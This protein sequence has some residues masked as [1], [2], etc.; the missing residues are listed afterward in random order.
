MTPIIIANW[1]MNL[2][3]QNAIHNMHIISHNK[4]SKG[5]IIAPP[6]AY[7]S[8]LS[9]NFKNINFCAQ[10][11]SKFQGLGTYTGECSAEIIKSCDVHYTLIG[12][13]D[14]RIFCNEDNDSLRNKMLNAINANITP[15]ICIGETLQE[16]KSNNYK[17]YLIN[18]LSDLF[19]DINKYIT[20]NTKIIIAYEPIWSIGSGMTPTIDNISEIFELIISN[21]HLSS[22]A[23]NIHLVYGGSVNVKNYHEIMSAKYISGVLIGGASIDTDQLAAIMNSAH[24]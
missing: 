22:I 14:R 13:S 7:L 16:R 15:I 11:I 4:N 24:Q 10:N 17:N 21:K 3:F 19:T 8:Y 5:L 9:Q 1:K 20:K 2:Q 18:Q 23:K 12:H 6:T